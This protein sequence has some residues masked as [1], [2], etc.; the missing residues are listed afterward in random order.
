MF[1]FFE[2]FYN[3]YFLVVLLQGI[4][5]FHSIRRGTQSKWLWIIVFLPLIGCIAYLFT[6]VIKKRH[7]STV[8]SGVQNMVNPSGKITDLEKKFKFS[9]TL[10]NRV[11]LA[12]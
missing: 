1:P 7:V 6:E 3:Y 4:C 2:N 5:V 8:Q 10:T 9:D 11:A 12:D